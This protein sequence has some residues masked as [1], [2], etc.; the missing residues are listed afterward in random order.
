[1]SGRTLFPVPSEPES[2]TEPSME[3]ENVLSPQETKNVK[4]KM[5]VAENVCIHI[6]CG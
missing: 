5:R 4:Y 3:A 6:N 2:H 1:M